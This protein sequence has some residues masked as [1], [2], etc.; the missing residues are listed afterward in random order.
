MLW[1]WR[2]GGA[3]RK[4]E[5]VT[6][7]KICNLELKISWESIC[8]SFGR[9]G[10]ENCGGRMHGWGNENEDI[11]DSAAKVE[12]FGER[13]RKVWVLKK[14]VIEGDIRIVWKK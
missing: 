3:R 10:L 1:S 13:D 11:V 8:F 7:N 14:I 2:T 4:R 5:S 12:K 9:A 6:N